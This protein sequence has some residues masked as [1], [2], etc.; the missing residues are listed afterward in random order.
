MSENWLFLPF[1]APLLQ[2]KS[3][4]LEKLSRVSFAVMYVNIDHLDPRV[5]EMTEELPSRKVHEGRV[6]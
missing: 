5:L 2:R 4:I 6:I 1:P 3:H